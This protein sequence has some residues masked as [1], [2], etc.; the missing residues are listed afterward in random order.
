MKGKW[1][2]INALV[3]IVIILVFGWMLW[4]FS[5]KNIA[6]E[7]EKCVD[8]NKVSSFS[9]DSCYDA[10]SETIFLEIKRGRDDY[11]I[12]FL[13]VSFFDFDAQFYKLTDVPIMGGS[14]AYKIP[15]GKNPQN[16]DI[17]FDIIKNFSAPI[18][19]EA[20]RVFVRYCPARTNVDEFNV[21]ISPL[22]GV[23]ADD[24]VEIIK[25]VSLNSDVFDLSLV[26]REKIWESKCKS[27]WKCDEWENCVDG[28]QKRK[29]EDVNKC[30]VSTDIP[31]RMRYCDG[32]CVEN[33][34]CKWS[35][36]SE[37]Y[38]IPTCKD[39]NDCRTSYNIPQKLECDFGNECVPDVKCGEWTN[40]EVNY[41]FVDL[42]GNEINNLK[43][44]KSRICEDK[45]SCI[46]LKEE[47]RNCSVD[48][49]IYIKKFTRCGTEFVGVYNRLN[50]NL[51]ARVKEGT[52]KNPYIDIYFGDKGDG[53]YCD[54]CYDGI[55]DG[56]E[57]GVDCGGSCISCDEKYIVG[58]F[59]TKSWWDRFWDWIFGR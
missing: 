27:D 11:E 55:L 16:L 48:V 24:Y 40:C 4:S 18:C 5:L 57:T 7:S 39:L 44:V 26:D 14:Q 15:A 17:V 6:I 20:K 37:G 21:S 30:F 41:N 35:K 51:I 34:E 19:D 54:Y 12:N 36:C 2:I 28:I 58:D 47:V 42:I 32:T 22:E 8:V 13:E 45:S 29:C 50:N 46:D 31:L 52:G 49:D 1:L 3:L 59:V 10:Y 53:A 43:G 33:W 25:G 38:T 56:D 9:Y 23:G